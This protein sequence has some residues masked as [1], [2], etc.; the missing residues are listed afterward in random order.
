M[1]KMVPKGGAVQKQTKEEMGGLDE[2]LRWK[3]GMGFL[4][5]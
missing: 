1:Q 4:Q 5:N 2:I 3:R